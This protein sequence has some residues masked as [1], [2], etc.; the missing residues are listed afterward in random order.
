MADQHSYAD[1]GQQS[2][3]VSVTMSTAALGHHPDPERPWEAQAF[4]LCEHGPPGRLPFYS[5]LCSW[6]WLLLGRER[7]LYF[8]TW[9]GVYCHFYELV[10]QLSLSELSSFR[11]CIKMDSKWGEG[12]FWKL[13]D[14]EGIGLGEEG[15]SGW[16]VKLPS[17]APLVPLGSER[18][19]GRWAGP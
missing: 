15:C 14:G 3:W 1:L 7:R 17:K 16:K 12:G 4:P 10:L 2:V 6:Q 8:K 11:P 9:E 19:R 5:F 13:L 18:W